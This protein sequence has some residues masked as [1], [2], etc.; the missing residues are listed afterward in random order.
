MTLIFTNDLVGCKVPTDL[1]KIRDKNSMR[2]GFPN[3]LH[4]EMSFA[5]CRQIAYLK[6]L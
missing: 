1:V 6:Y 2:M 5:K 4:F 3:I